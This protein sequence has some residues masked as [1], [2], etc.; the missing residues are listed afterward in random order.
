MVHSER[1]ARLRNDD[2]RIQIGR[3]YALI[4]RN[5]DISFRKIRLVEINA[6]VNRAID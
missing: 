1:N 3:T 6:Y 2:C 4:N 5:L